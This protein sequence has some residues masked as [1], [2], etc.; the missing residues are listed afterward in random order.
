MNFGE[1][2]LISSSDC[3]E[4]VLVSISSDLYV[5]RTRQTTYFVKYHGHPVSNG[6]ATRAPICFTYDMYMYIKINYA[7][8]SI[9]INS[10]KGALNLYG[11]CDR[12]C[13][14]RVTRSNILCTN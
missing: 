4:L 12:L 8:M 10:H 11:T 5:C 9:P 7:D 13:R 14:S 3:I 6:P 2:R 1:W